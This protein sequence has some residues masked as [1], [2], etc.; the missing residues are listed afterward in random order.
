M[1][2]KVNRKTL[3]WNFFIAIQITDMLVFLLLFYPWLHCMND[4]FPFDFFLNVKDDKKSKTS[5]FQN[6]FFDTDHVEKVPH[7]TDLPAPPIQPTGSGS[8]FTKEELD[9]INEEIIYHIKHHSSVSD[10]KFSTYFENTFALYQIVQNN[11]YF[12]VSTKVIKLVLENNYIDAIAECTHRSL[13]QNY[14]IIIDVNQVQ[15]TYSSNNNNI[16]NEFKQSDSSYRTKIVNKKS[17][18]QSAKDAKFTLDIDPTTEEI[19]ST[20]QSAYISHMSQPSVGNNAVDLGKTFENFIVGPSNH[21]AYA[22]AMA[23][24]KKPGKTGK[25]PSLFIWSDSGLGKTHLLHSVANGIREN[26]PELVICLIS[27]KEFIDQMIRDVRNNNYPEFTKRYTEKI[28]VLMIDDIHS[29]KKKEGSQ[30]NLFHIFNELHKNGKQLIFTSDR[31]P[32]EI[33]GIEERIKT[34]LQWGLVVDIQKPDFETR[35]AILKKK[36]DELDLFIPDEVIDLIARSKTSNIRELEGALQILCAYSELVDSV[37]DLETAREQLRIDLG[38]EKELSVDLIVKIVCKHYKM[39]LVDLRSNARSKEYALPRQIAM[40]IAQSI[41]KFT[42]QEIGH[43][44]NGRH[45]STVLNSIQ[46]IKKQLKTDAELSKDIVT[47]ESLLK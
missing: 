25:Y 42:L 29:L 24:S 20:V 35:M 4:N 21:M 5:L 11:A 17:R 27:A 10:Q 30:D 7:A 34:R 43:Y 2:T 28:D 39:H 32:K 14:Q 19:N 16:L 33:D 40:Y 18:F 12:H 36:T 3:I 15:T 22:S 13:G 23:V 6:H 1:N 31:S 41:G 9:I 47:I 45:H 8:E 26:Y 38:N 46:R 44:F 37:I